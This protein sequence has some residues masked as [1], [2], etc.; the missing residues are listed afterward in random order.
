MRKQIK[1]AKTECGVKLFTTMPQL[2]LPGTIF[3]INPA[4][5]RTNRSWHCPENYAPEWG[6]LGAGQDLGMK[7]MSHPISFTVSG[8][9][10]TGQLAIDLISQERKAMDHVTVHPVDRKKRSC[11]LL[12]TCCPDP[13]S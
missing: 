12:P 5:S 2:Y 7:P 10:Q 8:D 6:Q 3:L 9:K 11:P 4:F 1:E 13:L